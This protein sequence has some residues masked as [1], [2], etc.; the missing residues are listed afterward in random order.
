MGNDQPGPHTEP[1]NVTWLVFCREDVDPDLVS[2]ILV[3]RPSEILHV[4]DRYPW[5]GGE[6]VSNVGLWKLRL[7]ASAAQDGIEEQLSHWLALLRPKSQ[8]FDALKR[9][10]YAPYID[11]KAE[12]RSLSICVAPSVLRELGDLNIALSV[13][14]YEQPAAAT[15]P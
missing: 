12:S 8:A 4:G 9:L 2:E 1:G 15:S 6:R 14:L 13:W 5:F 7:A 11:C 3:L 10:G